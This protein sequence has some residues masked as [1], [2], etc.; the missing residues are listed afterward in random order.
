[1]SYP[2]N[3]AKKEIIS[4]FKGVNSKYKLLIISK[5]NVTKETRKMIY[6]KN[7]IVIEI[8]FQIINLSNRVF[9]RAKM[10]LFRK[11]KSYFAYLK[12]FKN[13]SNTP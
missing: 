12:R 6:R 3:E 4:R 1:M 11:L 10:L 5:F 9:R 2:L 7:I 8:G 13:K